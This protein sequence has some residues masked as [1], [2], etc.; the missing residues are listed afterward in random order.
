MRLKF[1]EFQKKKTTLF[2]PVTL[3]D[4][5][6]SLLN[7]IAF[8]GVSQPDL[9]IELTD[10]ADKDLWVSK[11]KSLTAKLKDVARHCFFGNKNKNNKKCKQ[12]SLL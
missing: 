4:I 2:F 11:F 5:D 12:F 1:R 8:T 7:M 6:P 10:I 3:L 9:E